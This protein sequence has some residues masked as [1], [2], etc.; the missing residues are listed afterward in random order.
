M[1]IQSSVSFFY[2]INDTTSKEKDEVRMFIVYSVLTYDAVNN[3][4]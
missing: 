1:I 4:Y 2:D 3:K